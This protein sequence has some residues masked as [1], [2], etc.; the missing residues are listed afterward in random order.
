MAYIPLDDDVRGKAKAAVDVVAARFG[1]SGSSVIFIALNAAFNNNSLNYVHIILTLFV[2][3]MSLWIFST[4][5]LGK[6]FDIENKANEDTQLKPSK[7][8]NEKV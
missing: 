6:Q 8:K 7:E 1:K 5:S 2:C 4:I 3:I